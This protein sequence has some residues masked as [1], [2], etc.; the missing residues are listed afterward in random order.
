MLSLLPHRGIIAHGAAAGASATP[1]PCFDMSVGGKPFVVILVLSLAALVASCDLQSPGGAEPSLLP[2]DVTIAGSFDWSVPE[3]FGLDANSDGR[4]DIPNTVEYVLNLD[5][6]ACAAGCGD[7]APV[8]TVV[9]DASQVAMVD[10]QGVGR[11]IDTFGWTVTGEAIDPIQTSSESTQAIVE[12]SEGT[13]EVTLEVHAGPLVESLTQSVVVSDILIVSVGDSYAAGEGNPEVPG[14]PPQWADDGSTQVTQQEI[15]HDFAHRSGLA[16]PTQAALAIERADPHTSVTFVFLAVSGASIDQGVVGEGEQKVGGDGTTG[17]LRPQIDELIELMGCGPEDSTSCRR[18]V[19]ALLVSTG[20]NDIGFSFTLGSLIAL[21]PV[22]VVNPIYQNLL[23][24]LLADVADEIEALPVTFTRLAE[25]IEDLAVDEVYLTAYPGSGSYAAGGRILTCDEVGG[26]LLPG[27]EV[28]SQELDVVQEVLLGPLNDTLRAIAEDQSWQFVDGHL[29]DFA[30]HGYCGS[31][32]YAGGMFDGN[33][34]P[35]EVPASPP[36][37]RWFRQ[38]AESAAIQGGG[39]LF[40]PERLA[41]NGTF[42]P[43][44]YG[45][46]AYKRALLSAMGY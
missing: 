4:L 18:T 31:D 27:L 7:V 38:A 26:D 23:D 1:I 15:D 33:P 28:D 5:E 34:F 44:E 42:H 24:N 13:Y 30:A 21:D 3:R 22:L 45:H 29:P 8:F 14:D 40:R 2:G 20:G 11:P 25:A 46:Q 6:G 41:T 16:G 32:P 10:D 39:G 12:L 19:D 43:N 37:A 36:E 17:A 35:A 9:L